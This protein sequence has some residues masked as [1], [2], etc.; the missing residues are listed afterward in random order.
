[1]AKKILIV[2]DDSGE[3][4]EVLRPAS[5]SCGRIPASHRRDEEEIVEWR[6]PRLLSRL[7]HL[8]RKARLSDPFEILAKPRRAPLWP[9]S[10]PAHN[11]RI[12]SADR[13]HDVVGLSPREPRIQGDTGKSAEN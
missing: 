8:H 12:N 2:T 9:P 7:E 1:M 3:S 5:V 10:L 4:Y 11:R 13:C 6:H